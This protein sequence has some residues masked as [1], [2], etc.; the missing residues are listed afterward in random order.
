MKHVSQRPVSKISDFQGWQSTDTGIHTY[1]KHTGVVVFVVVV[2]VFLNT[3]D[4]IS[5]TVI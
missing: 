4:G 3:W 2:F 5:R 1:T